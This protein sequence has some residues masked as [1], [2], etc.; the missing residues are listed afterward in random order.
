MSRHYFVFVRAILVALGLAL[1]PLLIGNMILE[2]FAMHQARNEMNAIADR[3]I[4]RSEAAISDVVEVLRQMQV[5][6]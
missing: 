4:S 3:Y 2:N 6:G 5:K 1:L